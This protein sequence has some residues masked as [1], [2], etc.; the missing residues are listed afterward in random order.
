MDGDPP[1]P[2]R[3]RRDKEGIASLGSR[4]G[5]FGLPQRQAKEHHKIGKTNIAIPK[6]YQ[7]L[8]MEQR[9]DKLEQDG[10]S[11]VS[12]QQQIPEKMTEM[13][14][15]MRMQ[16][17]QALHHQGGNGEGTS[18]QAPSKAIMGRPSVN[19][20][21][22]LL[23]YTPKLVKLDF[24]RFNGGEDPTSWLCRADQFF[25]FHATPEAE[26][27]ALA[28]F[29]LE[30]DA[31]LWYQLLKQESPTITWDVFQE[32]LNARFGPTQFYDFFGELTKLQ[33]VGSVRDYWTQFEKLLA[34]VGQLSQPQQVSCFVSGLKDS[35]KADVLIG[36]SASLSAAN[37]LAR[38]Y[39]ARNMSQLKVASIDK[40]NLSTKRDSG[41]YRPFLS[42]RKCH[43]RS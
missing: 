2:Q 11:L 42:V 3:G 28:S 32:G 33:Q 43:Q 29:H 17:E 19:G 13:F 1:A 9:V 31:Q 10:S 4:R 34:K 27:V 7:S 39:E 35:I 21:P 23:S 37:N 22:S 18:T 14:E 16:M 24:P 12:G 36:K 15:N 30:G 40:L 26:K 41:N 6:W 25:Q 5:G 38:L 8:G 20:G